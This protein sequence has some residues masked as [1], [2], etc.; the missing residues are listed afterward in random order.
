MDTSGQSGKAN[1]SRVLKA[2]IC[3][4]IYNETCIRKENWHFFRKGIKEVPTTRAASSG[5]LIAQRY[6]VLDKPPHPC[7]QTEIP[8]KTVSPV[9]EGSMVTIHGHSSMSLEGAYFLSLK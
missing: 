4:H 1:Y 2:I 3:P 8:Q 5:S 6:S 7:L 9:L